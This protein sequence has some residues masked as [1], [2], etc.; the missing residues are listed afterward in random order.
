MKFS[1]LRFQSYRQGAVYSTLFNVVAKGIGFGVNIAIAYYFG[2]Q[3]SVGVY[4]YALTTV[5]TVALF[6]GMI[7]GA[8]LIPEA[9]HLLAKEGEHEFQRFLNPFL[10][11]YLGFG[12]AMV[13]AVEAR[14][15][16]FFSFFSRFDS[17]LIEKHLVL[18]R[19]V[20]GLFPFVLLSTF[21]VDIL[22][23]RRCFTISVL[24]SIFNGILVLGF[25]VFTQDRLGVLSAAT[26]MLAAYM[27]QVA[28]LLWLLKNRLQWGFFLTWRLP[29]Q[30]VFRDIAYAMTGNATSMLA[31][32][33]PHFLLSGFS[34]GIVAALVFAQSIAA[35][36]TTFLSDQISAVTAIKFNEQFSGNRDAEINTTF[37]RVT[38]FLLFIL[39]PIS[40]LISF[41]SNEIIAIT[42]ARGAFSEESV[43]DASLFLRCIVLVVPFLA[44]NSIISRLFMAARKIRQG[45]WYQIILN[46]LLII[47]MKSYVDIWGPY[48]Y[49]FAILIINLIN[50]IMCRLLLQR[51]FPMINYL[52]TLLH[53]ALIYIVNGVFIYALYLQ[54]PLWNETSGMLFFVMG[55]MF[56]GTG[57]LLLN[58]LLKMNEDVNLSLRQV[59]WALFGKKIVEGE[60]WR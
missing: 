31:T 45:F 35:V 25:I 7:N 27:I 38:R 52:G 29:E 59:W 1:L 6:L 22:V 14:P 26:G 39:V 2:T 24:A 11:I 37:Q 55:V 18:L 16:D 12:L 23:S 17:V 57:I 9:M 43:R 19:I 46:L 4:F 48:S 53:M 44:V 51:Y 56:H 8:V 47:I 41:Y 58:F 30:K 13:L 21:L 33:I 40:L 20:I 28:L 10:Y 34:A 60:D 15:T 32:Y 50:L 54:K 36:P 42:F 49:P 3:Q 5:F